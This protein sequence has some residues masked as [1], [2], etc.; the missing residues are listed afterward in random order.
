M[1]CSSITLALDIKIK[2]VYNESI[3]NNESRGISMENSNK[4]WLFIDD[5]RFPIDKYLD[6]FTIAR[7]YDEG[8]QLC[9]HRGCPQFISFDHDLGLES[10]TGHD[11]AKYLIERDLDL[12]G[13]FIPDNFTF[14]VHS[15]NSV[16]RENIQKLLDNYLAHRAKR[17]LKIK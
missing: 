15:A 5:E 6:T 16:G 13:A 10:L 2:T 3:T 9:E 4:W 11:F 17:G 8:V 14:Y 12:D 7:T 1:I